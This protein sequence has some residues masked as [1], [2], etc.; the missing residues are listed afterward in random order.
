MPG[1]GEVAGPHPG[2]PQKA[3]LRLRA[4]AGAGCRKVNCPGRTGM[5]QLWD[6]P[7]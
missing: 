2:Q 7:A 5:L 6:T 1:T 3:V 4:A